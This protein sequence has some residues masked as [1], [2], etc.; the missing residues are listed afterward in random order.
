[1]TLASGI[2]A[3]AFSSGDATHLVVW[4]AIGA[5]TG[6]YLFYRGFVMLRYKRLILNTP[7]SKV[8]SASMGLVEVSGM[9]VGP[10][11][12]PAGLTHQ[13]C[14]Y[15]RVIVSKQ[16]QSGRSRQWRRV[17]DESMC[18]PF[19]LE[20]STGRMLIHPE[21]AEI[22]VHPNFKDQVGDSFFGTSGD[23]MPE[24]VAQFLNS[25]G[26]SG[27]VLRLEEY[28]IKPDCPLF[29]LGTLGENRSVDW[30]PQAHTAKKS[31]SLDFRSPVSPV[32]GSILLRGLGQ[33]TSGGL[34][35]ATTQSASRPEPSVS[36]PPSAAP[37]NPSRAA[38]SDM[39]TSLDET[40]PAR[41]SSNVA[42]AEP[43]RPTANIAPPQ[44]SMDDVPTTV[45]NSPDGSDSSG[46]DL[47]PVAAISK[48][49]AG[50]PFTI[51]CRSRREFVASLGWKSA[52]CI[53]GGPI[54]T[55]ASLYFL[56]VYFNW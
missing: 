53:W 10:Q 46:F 26:L 33:L 4:A 27:G 7:F 12:I 28:C 43:A 55:L 41:I 8:R 25:R 32:S 18:V 54:L 22:D 2:A 42:V 24:N 1:L 15:Y 39:W 38:A 16:E 9:P 3:L 29:V 30:T 6:V 56:F 47:Q 36:T 37:T 19:F 50:D 45:A 17:A 51:S 34:K 49:A 35:I 40:V 13:A 31:L 48:G 11:T 44:A 21:G 52:A 20:D 23:M 14:Y 5:A